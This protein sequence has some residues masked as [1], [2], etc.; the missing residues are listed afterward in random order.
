MPQ[1]P[2]EA[3]RP[4]ARGASRSQ[5]A[6]VGHAQDPS[7]R[8]GRAR[9]WRLRIASGGLGMIGAIAA[10]RAVAGS[11][12][13]RGTSASWCR[14]AASLARVTSARHRVATKSLATRSIARSRSGPFGRS[15][16]RTAAR[17]SRRGCARW[18]RRA[19]QAAT[20]ARWASRSLEAAPPKVERAMATGIASGPIGQLGPSASR[21]SCAAWATDA[22]SGASKCRPRARASLAFQ[23]PS[24]RLPRPRR[25][26]VDA[27][28][29]LV[30]M[31]NG[32]IGSRGSSAAS[33]V[34][35]AV[36]TRVPASC[37]SR[38]TIV[39]RQ[40]RAI[41]G[42]TGLAALK[43]LA[44]RPGPSSSR[45]A[46]SDRGPLGSPP[47]ALPPATATR[48]TA[49]PSY[50]T[51]RM[52]ACLARGRRLRSRGATPVLVRRTPKVA[53]AGPLWTV[54]CSSGRDGPSAV[55]PA[56]PG[57][58]PA[59]ASSRRPRGSQA[60]C[61]SRPWSRSRSATL[62]SCAW[63][64]AR[65]ASLQIGTSGRSVTP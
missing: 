37:G 3:D 10:R 39:A 20:A 9:R 24:K 35:R 28:R 14:T 42:S 47:S 12:S 53:T 13:A 33:V 63:T 7:R 27:M 44:S 38:R 2:A 22:A 45:T 61:A 34:A 8:R 4:R 48:S 62:P 56:A 5:G 65:I 41:I 32:T 19:R 57:T 36:C 49:A 17:A 54:S 18:C 23:R 6:T 29:N 59:S 58:W 25:V 16:R 21:P 40:L 31:V 26:R 43:S 1:M 15:A 55:P 50:V 30:S 11:A 60:W 52:E 64:G 46:C 51:A